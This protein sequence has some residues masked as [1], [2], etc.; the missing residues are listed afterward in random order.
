MEVSALQD[1]RVQVR[2]AVL[3]TKVVSQ[4]RD[5][6]ESIESCLPQDSAFARWMKLWPVSE[7][8]K[9]YILFSGLSIFG[10]CLGR[11][12]WMDMDIHTIY[13]MLNLLLIGPSG[14]GKSTSIDEIGLKIVEGLEKNLQPQIIKDSTT[15]EKL[16]Q[17]LMD[18]SH[19]IIV[20]SE[21]ASFF[22][23]E[24]YK[25]GMIPYVTRLL[26]YKD[27]ISNST[28]KDGSSIVERPSVTVIGGSTVEWLQGQLPDTATA[29]GFLARF[30]IVKEDHKFQRVADPKG[31]LGRSAWIELEMERGKVLAELRALAT[32]NGGKVGF[33]DYEAADAYGYWYQTQMPE[34][35]H[36]SPFSARAGEFVLRFAM[37]LALS[38]H[39]VNIEAEDIHAAVKLYE[40]SSKKLQEVVVPY[41]TQGKLLSQVLQA[42]GYQPVSEAFVKR[43]MRNSAAAQDV[44]K[45]LQSLME[46]KDIARTPEG[47]YVRVKS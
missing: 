34:T 43:A 26:D 29:G 31:A 20:A 18:N 5:G 42:I 22:T 33:A 23:K 25:E 13:P 46:S 39:H 37:L 11:N 12:V 2:G 4:T 35:G 6:A 32:I 47:M 45:L 1:S 27:S 3:E 8:P 19:A 15:K 7:P 16:H 21:L 40:Y 28:R 36:L 10:A 30:F 38:R 41:T 24:K 44:T 17:D 14:I 9:S